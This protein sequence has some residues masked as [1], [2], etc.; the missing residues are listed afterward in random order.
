M[1]GELRNA[2][3][4]EDGFVEPDTLGVDLGTKINVVKYPKGPVPVLHHAHTE[5]MSQRSCRLKLGVF[6]V[7]EPDAG[8]RSAQPQGH[9]GS[10]GA[11]EPG[12]YWLEAEQACRSGS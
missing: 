2:K 6:T 4:R 11:A 1:L 12:I 5:T 3:R 8:S 10:G 7:H 9:S